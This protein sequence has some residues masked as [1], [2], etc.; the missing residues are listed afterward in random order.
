MNDEINSARDVTKT[1]ALRLHTF[2]SRTVGVLGVV[3]SDRVAYYRRPVKRSGARSEFDVRTI[4][5]LP[6]VDVFLVYQD[7]PGDIIKAAIDAGAKGLVIAT[8]GAGATSGTQGDAFDYAR[9]KGVIIVNGTRT[10]SGRIASRRGMPVASQ[11]A[12]RAAMT[13]SAEDLAPVKAR[14]LLML[15]LTTPRTRDEIQRIFEEY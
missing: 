9:E 10:G 2:Q 1:D 15:A 12:Q 4:T 7:A 13:V 14:I 11:G 5:S 6:R 3:D 8:A